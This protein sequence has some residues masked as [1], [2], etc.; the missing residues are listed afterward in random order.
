MDS[1]SDN[2]RSV[3]LLTAGVAVNSLGSG[4]YFPLSLVLLHHLTGLGFTTVG[5]VLTVATGVAL[6]TMPI[7]GTMVDRRGARDI[8]AAAL[9]LQMVGFL[10][11]TIVRDPVYFGLTAVLVAMGNQTAKTTQP[12]VIA[13]LATGRSRSKLLAL[14]RSMSNA[15]LGLGAL[16]L[17]MVPADASDSWFVGI[18]LV[19]AAT[20]GIASLV[21]LR[22]PHGEPPVAR[23]TVAYGRVLRD[24]TFMRYTAANALSSLNYAALSNLLPLL[25]VVALHLSP[26]LSGAL[27]AVNTAITATAGVPVVMALQRVGLS[28]RVSAVLGLAAMAI[29]MVGF[30][31]ASSTHGPTLVMAMIVAMVIYSLGEVAHSPTSTAMALD[32]APEQER[33]QYQSAYQMS[34]NVGAMLAPAVFTAL[35]AL[36]PLGATVVPAAASVCAALLLCR[37]VPVSDSARAS[38]VRLDVNDAKSAATQSHS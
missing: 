10:V 12:V 7:I 32:A 33:G 8:L 17:T 1:S 14:M 15:A 28:D 25:V 13:G 26:Q 30:G 22:L 19:N 18:A 35:I 4:L 3:R 9:L 21:I 20:F 11:Y 16:V 23:A 29:G 2:R 38:S 27:Y 37:K 36:G 31:A 5:I 6:A 34:W 24:R